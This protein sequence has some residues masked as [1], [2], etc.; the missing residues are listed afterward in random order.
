M[1]WHL[2]LFFLAL[3]FYPPSC[4]QKPGLQPIAAGQYLPALQSRWIV[5]AITG[6]SFYLANLLWPQITAII[7]AIDYAESC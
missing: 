2:K 6:S 1:M 7:I 3:S 5:G 4:T